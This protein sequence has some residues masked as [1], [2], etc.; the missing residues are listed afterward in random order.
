MRKKLNQSFQEHVVMG[1]WWCPQHPKTPD[2][3]GIGLSHFVSAPSR[4]ILPTPRSPVMMMVIMMKILM[5]WTTLCLYHTQTQFWKKSSYQ[6]TNKCPQRTSRR[7]ES[8]RSVEKIIKKVKLASFATVAKWCYYKGSGQLMPYFNQNLGSRLLPWGWYSAL[9][10]NCLWRQV[11]QIQHGFASVIGFWVMA[12]SYP[13]NRDEVFW[14]IQ[15][16]LEKRY[17]LF[18]KNPSD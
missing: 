4:K 8:R 3:N 7:V 16:L 11:P 18:D 14:R 17:K 12:L 15:T 6:A 13:H 1:L 5:T 9:L 2:H 10:E